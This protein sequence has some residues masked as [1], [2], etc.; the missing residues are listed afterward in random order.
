MPVIGLHET[1][2]AYTRDIRSEPVTP[3]R[4]PEK[5]VRSLHK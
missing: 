3:L 4:S 1:Y 2:A 5:P